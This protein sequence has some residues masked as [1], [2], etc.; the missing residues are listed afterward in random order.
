VSDQL[1][2]SLNTRVQELTSQLAKA[3]AEAKQRR[4]QRAD[5]EKKLT[6]LTTAHEALTAERDKLKTAADA[7]PGQLQTENTEL[8]SKLRSIDHKAAFTEA[9]ST[10]KGAD[11]KPLALNTGA[12]IETLWQQVQYQ[13]P[14]ADP[15]AAKITELIGKAVTA[16]PFL[17]TSAADA[18]RGAGAPN[19]GTRPPLTPAVGSGRGRLDTA[20]EEVRVRKSDMQNPRWAIENSKRL[21]EAQKAGLL[22]ITDD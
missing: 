18:A 14:D 10:T 3:N 22:V 9:L 15:D 8:K 7:T 17:F 21:G 19:A 13:V 1:I 20:H 6:E 12:T 2:A 11:G 5:V 16:H 4:H